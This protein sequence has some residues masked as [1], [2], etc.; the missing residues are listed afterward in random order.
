MSNTIN[1]NWSLG[2]PVTLSSGVTDG[3][4]VS[5]LWD[6]VVLV[7]THS[8]LAI[9]GNTDQFTG[10]TPGKTYIQKVYRKD[11]NGNVIGTAEVQ[12]VTNPLPPVVVTVPVGLTLTLA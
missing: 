2:A 7:G 12:T 5:E 6:G 9:S 11:S 10:L 1:A 3:G 8:G 4:V